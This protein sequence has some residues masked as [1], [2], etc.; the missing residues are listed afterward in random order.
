MQDPNTI[1]MIHRTMIQEELQRSHPD[2]HHAFS[3]RDAGRGPVVMIRASTSRM[4]FSLGARIAPDSR[5]S[6]DRYPPAATG[7]GD[8]HRLGTS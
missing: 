8:R 3:E 5:S 1:I 4:L 7:A 6:I 2:L